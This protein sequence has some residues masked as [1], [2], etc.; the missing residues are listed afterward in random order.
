MY[1][2]KFDQKKKGS[3]VSIEEIVASRNSAASAKKDVPQREAV[4][5]APA[6][7]RTAVHDSGEGDILLPGVEPLVGDFSILAPR[8]RGLRGSGYSAD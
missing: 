5:D 4:Q 2:G 8:F 3:G 7:K 1:Q 6:K